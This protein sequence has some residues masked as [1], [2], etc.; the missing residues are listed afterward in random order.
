VTILP[1]SHELCGTEAR[2]AYFI[3]I[4]SRDGN[5]AAGLVLICRSAT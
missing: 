4:S 5:A 3:L 2:T 1:R